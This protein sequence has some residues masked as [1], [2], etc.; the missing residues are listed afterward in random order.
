MALFLDAHRLVPFV[1]HGIHGG[2]EL[3]RPPLLLEYYVGMRLDDLGR[4]VASL[5]AMQVCAIDRL[6]S[7]RDRHEASAER[8]IAQSL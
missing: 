3:R 2:L 4:R 7:S 6:R 8:R 1:Y 5:I